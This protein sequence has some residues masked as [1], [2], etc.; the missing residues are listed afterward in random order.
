MSL[1][2]EQQRMREGKLTASAV[3]AFV[4]GDPEKLMSLWRLM[5][6]DPEHKEPDWQ[7]IWPVRLGEASEAVNLEF[8]EYRTGRILS[9]RGEVVTHPRH[10]WAC[11]TLDGFDDGLVG[12]VDAKHVG[13][14]EK[15]DV[16]VARYTAQMFWQMGCTSTQRSALSIIEGAREPVVEPVEW[17]SGYADALWARAQAF[18]E[19]V[20]S[21]TPPIALPPVEAPVKAEHVIDMTGNNEWAVHAGAFI[22]TGAAAKQFAKADKAI[23]TLVP[24]DAAKCF[25][26]GIVATRNKAGALYIREA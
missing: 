2:P 9:R 4:S 10:T 24:P 1:T 18:M 15:R 13:G 26:H 11:A 25:G 14:F 23:R 12:P 8:Y 5:V 7:H 20:W 21:L 6:G 19:C 3:G 16:I 17:D 22:E